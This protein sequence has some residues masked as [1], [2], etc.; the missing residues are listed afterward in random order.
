MDA[1][2]GITVSF[3]EGDAELRK[4][5]KAA[6]LEWVAP[7]V[8]NLKLDFRVNTT[9]TLIRIAFGQGKGS[10]SGAACTQAICELAPG[11]P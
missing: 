3:L 5:V 4:R 8:A 2:R 10:W 6:A 9:D 7:G 11:S 1:R